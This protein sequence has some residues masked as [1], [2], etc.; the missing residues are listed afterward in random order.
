MANRDSG[1]RRAAPTPRNRRGRLARACDTVPGP[2]S[3]LNSP[4]ST[5][6]LTCRCK[7]A[8]RCHPTP[9][10]LT[11]PTGAT[12]RG[13][14][15]GAQTAA[16]QNRVSTVNQA[17]AL[18]SESVSR[19]SCW[20]APVSDREP[21]VTEREPEAPLI[22]TEREPKPGAVCEP[23]GLCLQAATRRP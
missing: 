21:I 14:G 15:R 18:L 20:R 16:A 4:L 23:E 9:F 19:G 1:P 3:A 2:T 11:G 22:V 12:A 17:D 6:A 8:P 5:A 10:L 13:A 7:S